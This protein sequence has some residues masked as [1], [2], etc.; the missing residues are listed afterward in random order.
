VLSRTGG[1]FRAVVDWLRAGYP[2]DAP[3]QGYSPL[4]ALNGP[5]GLSQK[6]TDQIIDELGTQPADPV[7]IKVAITKATDRLPTDTQTRK[8][9][10]AL[11][12]KKHDR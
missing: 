7:E 6:Q 11:D 8:I 5:I 1:R 12:Q 2:D 9:S 4:M 3:A 10:R